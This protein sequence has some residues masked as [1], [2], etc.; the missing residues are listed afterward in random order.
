MTRYFFNLHDGISLPDTI[1]SEHPDLLSAR[2]EAV[3]TIAERLKGAL[4][5]KADISSWLMNVTDE[6]GFTVM[7]LSFSAAVQ[8]VDQPS[9][10][11][12]RAAA[13]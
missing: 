7:V 9:L 2:S 8:F 10:A 5:K 12:A 11:A 3:E 1:G 13:E 4:L 6:Y